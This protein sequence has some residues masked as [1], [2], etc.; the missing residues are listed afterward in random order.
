[1]RDFAGGAR[2]PL[3]LGGKRLDGSPRLINSRETQDPIALGQRAAEACILH[4]DRHSRVNCFYDRALYGA[5]L[6]SDEFHNCGGDLR[7]GY[8]CGGN[9]QR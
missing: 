9:R 6:G 4:Y 3:R 7:G 8:D 1:M 2:M 5:G